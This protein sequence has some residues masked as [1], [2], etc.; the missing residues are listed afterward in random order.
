MTARLGGEHGQAGREETNAAGLWASL[1]EKLDP[2]MYAPHALPAVV[3]SEI[4]DGA[5]PYYVLKSPSGT[6][7]RLTGRDYFLWRQM[8]G[9]T[10]IKDL[11]VAYFMEY[12]TFAF[13]RVMGLVLALRANHFFVDQPTGVYREIRSQLDR[14]S[15][16]GRLS[17]AWKT[18]MQ[19]PLAISGI[20]RFFTQVYRKGGWLLFTRPAQMFY[21]LISLVGLILFAHLFSTGSYSIVSTAGSFGLGLVLLLLAQALSVFLHEM[22]H[23]LTV[24]HFGR[25]VR[26]AGM[27]LMFGMPAFFVDTTDIWLEN[28]RARLAVTWAGPYSGLVLAGLGT[29]VILA[30][31]NMPLNPL[32]F[33]FAFL[34]YLIVFFNLNP[35]LELDGYYMLVDW[36][37]IPMLRQKSFA[38]LREGAPNKW[39]EGRAKGGGVLAGFRAL[40]SLTRDEKVFVVFGLL[41]AVW[42]A[43]AVYTGL[44]FWENRVASSAISL[45]R[46][47]GSAGRTV[48]TIIGL[49]LG[50]LFLS[51]LA[52]WPYRLL[53]SLFRNARRQGAFSTTARVAALS[54]TGILLVSILSLAVGRPGAWQSLAAAGLVT[55]V[56]LATRVSRDYAGS[57]LAIVFSMLAAAMAALLSSVVLPPAIPVIV[58]PGTLW[59]LAGTLE[60]LGLLLLVAAAIIHFAYSGLQTLHPT[61]KAG[62]G[63]GLTASAALAISAIPALSGAPDIRLLLRQL[64]PV[65]ALTFLAPT[66][67]SYWP[68]R[69]G[70]AWVLLGLGISALL[71]LPL[72]GLPLAPAFAMFAAAFA[73]IRLAYNHLLTGQLPAPAAPAIDDREYLRTVFKHMASILSEQL[74]Q[75]AGVRGASARIARF[76]ELA[77]AAGWSVRIGSAG[78]EDAAPPAENLI[79]QGRRYAAALNLLVRLTEPSIGKKTVLRALQSAYDGLTWEERELAGRHFLPDVRGAEALHRQFKSLQH[80]YRALIQRMPLFATLTGAEVDLLASRL[81]SERVSAGQAIIRQ[82]EPGNKFYIISEGHIEAITSQPNGAV[83]VVRRMNRGEY[84]GE[85]ALLNDA[86][87]NA[88]CRATAPSELLSLNRK[89][90]DAL[91]RDRFA[92]REKVDAALRRVELLRRIPLFQDMDAGQLQEVAAALEERVYE[93]GETLIQQG[94]TGDTLFIIESGRVQV[95]VTRDGVEW[96]VAERG[97]GEYVG[98][99]ALLMKAPRVATVRSVSATRVQVLAKDAFDHLIAAQISGQH[100]LEQEATRRLART[101]PREN[102][103]FFKSSP[104]M[105]GP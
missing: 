15:V 8:D 68:T 21:I 14:R 58:P 26:R 89:D 16:R 20:D 9:A 37:G 39:R 65:L 38:F 100:L 1:Q 91:V 95:T 28:R 94:E 22:A 24:K 88:T 25:E 2:A 80:T 36:L 5:E 48:L 71:V 46:G 73:V 53:R 99:I 51:A 66:I 97:P 7:H 87:R 69:S 33:K 45:W 84:F 75:A 56:V 6:Y 83:E 44:T 90:F 64:C 54:A 102:P 85:L 29:L 101:R 30:W 43:Y 50:L 31:P 63:F 18:V 49:V 96:P 93:A 92:L 60:I 74:R 27:L 79:E 59:G 55:A 61:E 3:V 52:I 10:T 40:G 57:H 67:A 105:E 23:G 76:N 11:V 17:T 81:R 42:T 86:P 82:G 4:R 47:G 103:A 34:S 78:V 70:P 62:L 13:T 77:G 72:A 104:I 41:A 12:G 19:A 32:L 35:L 98:E